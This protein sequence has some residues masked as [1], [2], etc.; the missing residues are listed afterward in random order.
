MLRGP[1]QS[2]EKNTLTSAVRQVYCIASSH[3]SLIYLPPD[4]FPSLGGGGV[5]FWLNTGQHCQSPDT[6]LSLRV[7]GR[8]LAGVTSSKQSERPG[9]PKSAPGQW[10]H[11]WEQGCPDRW[12]S[13]WMTRDDR[14]WLHKDGLNKD[15][16]QGRW[17]SE[18]EM[19]CYFAKCGLGWYCRISMTFMSLCFTDILE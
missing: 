12:A 10:S 1:F 13:C 3:F 17:T 9:G 8:R 11:I 19:W 5:Y 15:T 4:F 16:S 18:P 6:L 7:Q 2:K 14:L